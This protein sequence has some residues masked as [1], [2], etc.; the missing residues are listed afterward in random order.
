LVP[1]ERFTQK[2]QASNVI[3]YF[4]MERTAALYDSDISILHKMR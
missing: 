2:R 4:M 1:L 3:V